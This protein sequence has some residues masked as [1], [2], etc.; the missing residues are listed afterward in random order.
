VISKV[1][2][3]EMETAQTDY[4]S[5]SEALRNWGRGNCSDETPILSGSYKFDGYLNGLERPTIEGDSPVRKIHR[6]SW[7]DF[8]SAHI[9]NCALKSVGLLS[10]GKSAE[11]LKLDSTAIPL[12]EWIMTPNK[13]EGRKNPNGE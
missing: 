11:S 9:R 1:A 8:P 5:S 2:A 10:V 3:S 4:V 12:G 6:T 7:S 13:P